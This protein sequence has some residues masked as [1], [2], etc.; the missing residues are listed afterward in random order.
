MRR[1]QERNQNK[2]KEEGRETVGVAIKDS[3]SSYRKMVGVAM[4]RWWE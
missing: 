4:G 1:H 3:G 2:G